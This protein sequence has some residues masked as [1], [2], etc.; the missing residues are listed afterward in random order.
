MIRIRDI[1]R[2]DR[3]IE[4]DTDVK[5]IALVQ[6]CAVLADLPEVRDPARL[7][8][9]IRDRERVIST[10]VGMG[11]AIP[12]ARTN[13]VTDFV[14][15]V[16]RHRTGLDFEALDGCPVYLAILIASP[17][18]S[19]EAFLNLTAD[20]GALCTRPGFIVAVR[21]AVTTEDVYRLFADGAVSC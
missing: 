10:G 12:H 4:L 6:L 5:D 16:G 21:D 11:V 18:S 19:R 2:P 9:A 20:I 15:A 8:E 17:E 13:A 3:V 14:M 7:L 1:L